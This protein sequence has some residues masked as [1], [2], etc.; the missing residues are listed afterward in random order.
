MLFN[1]GTGRCHAIRTVC[2]VV[3]SYINGESTANIAAIDLSIT[4]KA[5]DKHY[6][7]GLFLKL[8]AKYIPVQLLALFM[9]ALCMAGHCIFA[10][11]FLSFF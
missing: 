6:H 2:N 4:Y 8:M 9:A 1:N 7:H 5:F 11:W 10:L 3:D